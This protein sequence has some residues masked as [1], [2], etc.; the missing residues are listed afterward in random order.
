M[1]E[2]VHQPDMQLFHS[3]HSGRSLDVGG[4]GL[5]PEEQIRFSASPY[6]DLFD[7]LYRLQSRS[8]TK[9]AQVGAESLVFPPGMLLMRSGWSGAVQ[10]Y[11]KASRWHLHLHG[12]IPASLCAHTLFV[13]GPELVN[14]PHLLYPATELA[15]SWNY[16]PWLKIGADTQAMVLATLED[17]FAARAKTLGIDHP[18]TAAS[19]DDLGCLLGG[20]NN[21]R[22]A[23]LLHERAL[24]IRERALGSDH[25]E[26]AISLN[27]LSRSMRALGDFAGAQRTRERL[28]ATCERTLGPEHPK[29]AMSLNNLANL[30]CDQGQFVM[31]QRLYEQSLTIFETALGPE[32]PSTCRGR[33]NL[34]R[35]LDSMDKPYAASLMEISASAQE[36]RAANHVAP[37]DRPIDA[38]SSGARQ[39]TL[40]S[41][42]ASHEVGTITQEA[43]G[44][45]E[46]KSEF[47]RLWLGNDALEL[48]LQVIDA[49]SRLTEIE[50]ERLT[51]AAIMRLAGRKA[52]D[53]LLMRAVA[54]LANTSARV[55]N[56]RLLF[57]DDDDLE[58][59]IQKSQL[60]TARS[61]GAFAHP[62]TGK[63]VVDFETKL[64][65]FFV[66]SE[67]FKLLRTGVRNATHR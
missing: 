28:L 15:V 7:I 17:I 43:R 56:S 62:V 14:T 11:E 2:L 9:E 37:I 44:I 36:W 32:H 38:A 4:V 30:V 67:E 39:I 47:K 41:R 16:D 12:S 51:F 55:L 49:L 54:L 60:A 1:S 20:R 19:L 34:L 29:T 50:E 45:A 52:I 22:K 21:H 27:N 65:P 63:L 26:T 3:A 42:Q 8:S 18:D 13:E 48:S 58:F 33:D 25:F 35:L 31:A 10:G 5:W 59:E 61:A 53:E 66:I 64:V 24:E 23:R 40:T 57:V 6:N 46:I